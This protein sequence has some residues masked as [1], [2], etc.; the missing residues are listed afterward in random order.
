MNNTFLPAKLNK[1]LM[2]ET[3]NI[4]CAVDF[5]EISPKMASYAYTLAKALNANVHVIHVAPSQEMHG[6]FEIPMPSIQ[7]YE[8]IARQAEK[9]MDSFWM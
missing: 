9:K 5:S 2:V 6:S 7:S 3:R 1:A 4:L 8:E